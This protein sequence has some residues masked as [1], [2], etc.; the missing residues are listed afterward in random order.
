MTKTKTI[1]AGVLGVVVLGSAGLLIRDIFSGAA[2]ANERMI[3]EEMA[4]AGMTSMSVGAFVKGYGGCQ[5]DLPYG[6][7][8]TG[9]DDDGNVAVGVICSSRT[10]MGNRTFDLKR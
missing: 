1:C 4:A 8:F 6:A 7:D 9:R 10:G 3:K 5:D 2:A